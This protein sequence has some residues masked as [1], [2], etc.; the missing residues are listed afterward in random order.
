MTHALIDDYKLVV[1]H[2]HVYSLMNEYGCLAVIKPKKFFRQPKRRHSGI[3]IL[4]RNFEA[5]YPFDKLATDV[6]VI[7]KVVKV[8]IYR[9]LRIYALI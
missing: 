5:S 1:N 3:N 9:Q 6:S 2:K 7:K 4:N 8:S